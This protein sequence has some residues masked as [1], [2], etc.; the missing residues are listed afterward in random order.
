MSRI[1]PIRPSSTA[2]TSRARSAAAAATSWGGPHTSSAPAKVAASSSPTTPQ[3]L[4]TGAPVPGGAPGPVPKWVKINSALLGI[5]LIPYLAVAYLIARS[6]DGE[7]P[8]HWN[9]GGGVNRMDDP[10]AIV[11]IALLMAGIVG[12]MALLA[13]APS[14]WNSVPAFR[15]EA[16]RTRFY[17]L[18]Y[19]IFAGAGWGALGLSCTVVLMTAGQLRVAALIPWVVFLVVY[20]MTMSLVAFATTRPTPEQLKG[21]AAT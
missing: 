6:L 14:V 9:L 21:L 17:Q 12:L 8:V 7:A 15:D 2:T 5:L 11:G 4:N 1:P 10:M 18:G 13:L 3:G 16:A 19:A 20:P